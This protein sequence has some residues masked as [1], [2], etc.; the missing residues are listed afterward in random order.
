MKRPKEE[1]E[2][3]TKTHFKILLNICHFL[4]ISMNCFLII[5]MFFAHT[6]VV[7]LNLWASLWLTFIMLLER[8]IESNVEMNRCVTL[9]IVTFSQ[10]WSTFFYHLFLSTLVEKHMYWKFCG[11]TKCILSSWN[12]FDLWVPFLLFFFSIFI[13]VVIY[14]CAFNKIYFWL[15]TKLQ[16]WWFEILLIQWYK[17]KFTFTNYL[18]TNLNALAEKWKLNCDFCFLIV[19]F[20]IKDLYTT[21]TKKEIYICKNYLDKDVKL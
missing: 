8:V 17:N 1:D 6:S 13:V 15:E 16:S 10:F 2:R 21:I 19:S 14:I 20:V 4:P 7:L 3:F 12:V 9:Y 18:L 5:S 11:L